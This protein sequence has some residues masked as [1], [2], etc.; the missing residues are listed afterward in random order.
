MYNIIEDHSAPKSTW[1]DVLYDH[2]SSINSDHYY[3]CWEV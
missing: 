1:M 2:H 3:Q